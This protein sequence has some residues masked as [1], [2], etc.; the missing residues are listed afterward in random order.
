ME[1]LKYRIQREGLPEE[2]KK[3]LDEVWKLVNTLAV[4]AK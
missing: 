3:Q 4:E 1:E 2:D